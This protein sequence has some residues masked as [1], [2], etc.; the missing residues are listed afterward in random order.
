MF[1]SLEVCWLKIY[2]NFIITSA[3]YPSL[4]FFF[5][6]MWAG[7]LV[8]FMLSVW[9]KFKLAHLIDRCLL[10]FFKPWK[11]QS[12]YSLFKHC[13]TVEVRTWHKIREGIHPKACFWWVHNLVST[14][15][16]LFLFVLIICICFLSNIWFHIHIQI[17]WNKKQVTSVEMQYYLFPYPFTFPFFWHVHSALNLSELN[18]SCV[19]VSVCRCVMF[20]I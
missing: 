6:Q 9:L 2:F 14:L 10:W 4:I 18:M 3:N 19:E 5:I 8:G 7:F 15:L 12:L 16:C 11:L 17:V 13:E 20:S 1:I